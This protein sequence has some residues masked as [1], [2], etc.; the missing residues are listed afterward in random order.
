MAL[1]LLF[2]PC[3]GW[4]ASLAERCL[5]EGESE[6]TLEQ[7]YLD[8]HLLALPVAALEQATRA[9]FHMTELV[10]EMLTLSIQ[11]FE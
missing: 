3:A 1:A 9:V 2:V 6:A 4:L 8:H 5:P 11:A 10:T 7:V